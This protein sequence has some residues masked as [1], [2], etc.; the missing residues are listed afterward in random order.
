MPPTNDNDPYAHVAKGLLKLKN[1]Q[2]VN[3]KYV[4]DKNSFLI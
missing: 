1:D 4:N 2:G 3:K